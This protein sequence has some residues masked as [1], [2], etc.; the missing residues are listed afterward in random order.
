MSWLVNLIQFS[1]SILNGGHTSRVF[2]VHGDEMVF[3]EWV[4]G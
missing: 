2:P 3:A 4:H 1:E